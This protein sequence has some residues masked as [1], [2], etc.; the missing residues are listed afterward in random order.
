MKGVIKFFKAEKGYG[1]IVTEEDND[2]FFHIS[3]FA[4]LPNSNMIVE[5]IKVE[6]KK[7]QTDK[8]S[9]AVDIKILEEE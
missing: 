3:D 9:K 8:G 5:D 2:L 4:N 6:F 7:S 1:F